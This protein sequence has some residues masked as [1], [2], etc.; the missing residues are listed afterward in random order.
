MAALV[1]REV[2]PGTRLTFNNFEELSAFL[3]EEASRWSGL[4]ELKTKHPSMRDKVVQHQKQAL[5]KVRNAVNQSGRE[6]KKLEHALG[7]FDEGRE[8]WRALC[9]LIPADAAVLALAESDP[10]AAVMGMAARA[11]AS[12]PLNEIAAPARAE[13]I[14]ALY[15][16]AVAEGSAAANEVAVEG[17]QQ[18]VHRLVRTWQAEIEVALEKAE[19]STSKAD[20]REKELK[21]LGEEH[22]KAHDEL[23]AAHK[24]RLKEIEAKFVEQM[25]LRGPVKYWKDRADAGRVAAWIWLGGFG[26][27]AVGVFLGV[28]MAGPK[29]LTLLKDDKGQISLAAVPLLVAALIP[30]L[31]VLRHLARMFADS[32]ADARDAAQRSSLT[33]AF[34]ALSANE[35]VEFS[36]TERA[37]IVQALFRP[38]PAQPT[39]DGVP[40]PV[41]ELLKQR[42]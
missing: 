37:I 13:A 33:S 24:V 6:P 31:W 22:R 29:L 9:S 26:V 17:L 14:L 20:A 38:S 19:A 25:A 40:V 3:D 2:A 28:V 27:V 42:P 7:F 16:F 11:R 34:L 8:G 41:L 23:F 21:E 1:E 10:E 4:S 15:R 32:I 35:K 5:L 12:E 39:D 30:L 18:N 36:E